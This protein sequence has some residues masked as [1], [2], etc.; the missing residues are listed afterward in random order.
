MTV[1]LDR[2]EGKFG[3]LNY[4]I[5]YLKQFLSEYDVRGKDILEV[6]GAM[7]K[8][9]V[10]D[11]LGA[12]SWTCTE[13]PDYDLTLQKDSNQQS[14]RGETANNPRYTPI[15]KRIE[16]FEEKYNNTF[17]CIFSI[18]CFEHI[19]RFPEALRK[20]WQ[21]LKP[22]GKLF[23][24]FSP[25]WSCHEGHHLY[26]LDIP[27]R[28]LHPG[29][30]SPKIL[31]PWEHLLKNR[32]RLYVDLCARFDREFAEQVVYEV[33]NSPHINRY[34]SEDFQRFVVD[35]PFH[36]EKFFPTFSVPLPEG[37]QAALETSCPGY[38]R[39]DN[40]GLYLFASK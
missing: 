26:H 33:H 38:K 32:E 6:G 36:L 10:I 24:M 15:L 8:E 30:E 22:G 34:F 37:Y 18:A 21:V 29:S 16:D 13:D 31:Q 20:M 25:I 5:P 23:S 17:D 2:F 28:F 3:L 12:N 35:S 39:F 27:N 11:I 7:P 19:G 1:D 14:I 9:I 4:H 40:M